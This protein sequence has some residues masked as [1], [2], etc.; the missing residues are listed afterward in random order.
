MFGSFFSRRRLRRHLR[1]LRHHSHA[2]GVLERARDD[3]ERLGLKPLVLA[4]NF[5]LVS[6][7]SRGLA[8]LRQVEELDPE[9][10]EARDLREFLSAKLHLPAIRRDRVDTTPEETVE[11]L[12]AAFARSDRGKCRRQQ[13]H[14]AEA[15][16]L[17]RA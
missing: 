10:P 9:L 1:A 3:H 11:R 4:D 12:F 5:E 8:E 15:K 16:I 6:H 13:Q 14:E 2:I 17:E 7:A